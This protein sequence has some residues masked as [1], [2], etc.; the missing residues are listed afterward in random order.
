MTL[1]PA[2]CPKAAK[3]ARQNLLM[4]IK[5]CMYAFLLL[6]ITYAA[7]A[8][9]SGCAQIGTPTGGPKDTIP[10]V[11]VSA[12]P[13]GGK[14]NFTGNKITLTFNEYIDVQDI[15]KNVL[16]SPFPKQTPSISFKLKT[17]TVKLKDTL[18][19]NTTYVVNFGNAIRDLNEG[20]PFKNYQY[21]FST[22]NTIDSLQLS[23]RVVMAESG[24]ADSTLVA[25]LYRDAPDSA[26]ETRKP[27]YL[28]RLDGKGNFTFTNL[29]AGTYKLYALKDGDGGNTYN[30]VI[31]PF[32][33]LNEDVEIQGTVKPVTLFAY[34]QEKDTR[35][36]P[37][38]SSSAA[39]PAADKKLKYTLV[40]APGNP[41][42]LLAPLLINFS[43]PIKE[44]NAQAII[45]S[46]SSFNRI[47][48]TSISLDST[49]RIMSIKAPWTEETDYRLVMKTDAVADT[50]GNALPRTDTLR[51]K[52]RSKADYGS[53]VLHFKNLDTTKHPV[54]QF[55]KA[56]EL[57]RSIPITNATWSDRMIE[58]GEYELRILYDENGNALWDPGNYKEK[59]Q[60]EHVVTLPQKLAI[61][62][63]WDNERDV[64]L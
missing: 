62:A 31:E 46:D 39:K 4:K 5:Y 11:L 25:I 10:P 53:L 8:G 22:G 18:K 33:F 27:D 47:G 6:V 56:D 3:F 34:A 49:G 2:G 50:F 13:V 28:A 54:L 35:K 36:P 64:E 44:F 42:S 51:F 60:P 15:Q 12:S 59:K 38:T 16:V 26:V 55:F 23:G 9:L 40:A 48:N 57:Q 17:I 61:R 24:K 19:P 30:S 45:L 20:N 41:Q 37:P 63:N 14:T 29:S 43:R 58:P 21:V 32:A 1:Q 7:I 52:T